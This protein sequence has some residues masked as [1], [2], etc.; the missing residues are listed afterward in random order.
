MT[1]KSGKPPSKG[2]YYITSHLLHIDVFDRVPFSYLLK[3]L[4]DAGVS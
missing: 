2:E 3:E 1:K 4:R